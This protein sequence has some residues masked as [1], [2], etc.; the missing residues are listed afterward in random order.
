MLVHHYLAITLEH[1][2]HLSAFKKVARARV[3]FDMDC[4]A[5]DLATWGDGSGGSDGSS[6]GCHAVTKAEVFALLRS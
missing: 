3:D 6:D 5:G 4:P 1:T 2:Q